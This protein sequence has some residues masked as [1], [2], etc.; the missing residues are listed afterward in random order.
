MG[1][2]LRELKNVGFGQG[3]KVG[4]MAMFHII[5]KQREHTALYMNF[6]LATFQKI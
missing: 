6:L 3:Q 2:I 1:S 4:D 5:T